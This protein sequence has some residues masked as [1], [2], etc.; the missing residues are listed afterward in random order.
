MTLVTGATGFVGN[1]VARYLANHGK[2][3]RLLV[4]P[5]SDRST[6]AGLDA[7]ICVGDIRDRASV[8]EAIAGCREIYHVAAEYRLWSRTPAGLYETNV[9]GTQNLLEAASGADIR[10]FVYTSSI[11]TIAPAADGSAVTEAS[12]STLAD[13]TG[14]YK[15]SKFLAE[16]EALRYAA[17]GLPV[18]VVSPTA[19]V[20]E[21]DFKPTPTGRIISD[22]LNGRMPAYVD[23]GLNLVDVRDVARGHWLAAEKGIPGERYLLGSENLSLRQ[24]LETAAEISG[25]PAPRIRL[26]YFA[27]WIAGACS[28]GWSALSGSAPAVPMEGVRMARRQMFADCTKARRELGFEPVPVRGAIARAI[29]WFESQVP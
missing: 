5:S 2:K 1:H 3:L 8:A 13:M 16:Q 19:P 14:H 24:I 15:R 22:F 6:L 29:E 28:T 18:V 10:R 7:Q 23:T 26:P 11:G 27:A 12:P 17:A 4:R 20:G 25:R 21:A 9:G